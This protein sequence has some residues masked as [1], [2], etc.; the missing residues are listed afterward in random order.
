M[1]KISLAVVTISAL[2]TVAPAIAADLAVK[3]PPPVIVPPYSWTGCYIG[4][5]VG[6]IGGRDTSVALAPAGK[7]LTPPGANAPPNA[8]GTGDFLVDVAALTHAYSFGGSGF[9]GGG[10]VGCNQQWNQLV[11]GVEGDFNGTS[12]NNS[13]TTAFPAFANI[14]NPAFT[15]AAHTEQVTDRLDWYSTVRARAGLAYDQFLVY[16]TGGVAF[17]NFQSNTAVQFATFPVFPVYNGAQHFGSASTTR[18]GAVVGAG[19]EYAFQNWS[20]KVEYLFIDFGSSLNYFSPL[21]ASGVTPAPVG[22][23]GWSTQMGR[24]IENVVHV[25]LNYHFNWGAPLMAHY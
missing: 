16:A 5:N 11:L 13:Q 20:V 21:V 6:W 9:E 14:G 15:N 1:G 25:G 7:Y 10:Q 22:G 23:Y 17:G 24:S 18:T 19:L 3:A 12:L 4:G 2:A 8:Q